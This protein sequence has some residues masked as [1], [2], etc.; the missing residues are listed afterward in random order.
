MLN[1]SP[2]PCP[3]E[4]LRPPAHDAVPAS[5][6]ASRGPGPSQGR[7]RWRSAELLGSAQ[8]V[9]IEHGQAVYRLKLTSLGKLILTK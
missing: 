4:V 1:P 3:D 9:E 5:P 6:P 2:L 7:P 8:E